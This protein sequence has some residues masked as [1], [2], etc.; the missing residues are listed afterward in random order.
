M[1]SKS[2]KRQCDNTAVTGDSSEG[3]PDS[4]HHCSDPQKQHRD[5]WHYPAWSGCTSLQASSQTSCLLVEH[6]PWLHTGHLWGNRIILLCLC[7]ARAGTESAPGWQGYGTRGHCEVWMGHLDSQSPGRWPGAAV[8][9]V[10][11]TG[12]C[13]A[14]ALQHDHNREGHVS[15]RQ[16]RRS[17]E[18]EK[19]I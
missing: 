2:G 10:R 9:C 16:L 13:R 7:L 4:E 12:M 17:W 8:S 1:E 15:P 11:G 6:V 14:W 18:N 3:Q 19:T 5:V